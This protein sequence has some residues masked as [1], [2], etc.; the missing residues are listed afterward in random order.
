M[1]KSMPF[2]AEAA[3]RLKAVYSSWLQ[4]PAPIR[5]AHGYLT[6]A[7]PDQ[8]HTSALLLCDPLT[9]LVAYPSFEEL[10]IAGLPALAIKGLHLAIGDVD[11]LRG[12]VNTAR[13]GDP[14]QFG[15][16]AGNDC[17]RRVGLATRQWA[18]DILDGWPFAICATFGG[19]EVIVAA[20]G[21]PYEEF[22]DALSVLA[23][24]IRTSAPRP[25]SFASATSIPVERLIARDEEIYRHL[26]S[27]V[28]R[29]LFCYKAELRNSGKA[30]N[31]ALIDIG[32]VPLVGRT[33]Q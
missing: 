21:R 3:W 33:E 13:G 29:R 32:A 8:Q 26:L 30:L 18:A 7:M 2:A 23:S 19:D 11:D 9:G 28:D 17:M 12:Y 10:I 4:Q 14:T 1:K 27:R 24:R 15:H 6:V 5:P 31:G 25:C 20:A 22:L 16:L